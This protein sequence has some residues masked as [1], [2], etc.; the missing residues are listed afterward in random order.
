[1]GINMDRAIFKFNIFTNRIYKL[2]DGDYNYWE[3]SKHVVTLLT[4]NL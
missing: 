2:T 3:F 1:M 4:L